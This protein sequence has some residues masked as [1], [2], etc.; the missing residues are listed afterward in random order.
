MALQPLSRSTGGQR[1]RETAGSC[2]PY[3]SH[4][5]RNGLVASTDGGASSRRDRLCGWSTFIAGSG[6]PSTGRRQPA[7]VER[8]GRVSADFNLGARCANETCVPQDEES[9]RDVPGDRIVEQEDACAGAGA[10]RHV[11]P[12]AGPDRIT[13]IPLTCGARCSV[14]PGRNAGCSNARPTIRLFDLQRRPIPKI[15]LPA[16]LLEQGFD[17]TLLD[18]LLVPIELKHR[19][20]VVWSTTRVPQGTRFRPDVLLGYAT[21]RIKTEYSTLS[22]RCPDI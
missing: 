14:A 8:L 16:G 19:A 21:R 10:L 17:A 6:S 13:A 11:D 3:R 9:R 18:R 1:N 12:T 20:P 4:N 22:S 7:E 5:P 15:R 2:Q